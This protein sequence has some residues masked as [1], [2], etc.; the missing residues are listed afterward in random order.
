MCQA[1]CTQIN[2]DSWEQDTSLVKVD[3]WWTRVWRRKVGESRTHM[4]VAIKKPL[5]DFEALRQAWSGQVMQAWLLG[6]CVQVF[7]VS[8]GRTRIEQKPDCSS[9]VIESA[10]RSDEGRYTIK[11]T[12]PVGEDVASIFLRVVG[13]Q[14]V[15]GMIREVTHCCLQ[16]CL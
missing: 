14:G 8:E 3:V 2:C 4:H 7:T 12:N 5:K 6:G 1:V 15:K 9:F 13:K 11:V 16:G 10:E